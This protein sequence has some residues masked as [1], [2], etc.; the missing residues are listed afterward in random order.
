MN[1]NSPHPQGDQK[2]KEGQV[3]KSVIIISQA[4]EIRGRIGKRP[5]E[6]YMRGEDM[7]E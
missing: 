5:G 4:S 3:H 7:V 2:N 1:T 6:I